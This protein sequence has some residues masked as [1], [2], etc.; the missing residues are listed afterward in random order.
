MDYSV[1]KPSMLKLLAV[2]TRLIAKPLADFIHQRQLDS[3][4]PIRYL[5]DPQHSR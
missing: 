2:Y 5:L 1:Q 3:H 4:H